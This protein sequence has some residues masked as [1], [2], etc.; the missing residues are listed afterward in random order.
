MNFRIRTVLLV[1]ATGAT[2]CGA[3]DSI[4]CGSEENPATLRIVDQ[5]P[6][7]GAKVA[8][9][10]I[11]EAFTLKDAFFYL[12]P[13]EFDSY[14]PSEWSE[15]DSGKDIKYSRRVSSWSSAP[16]HVA[17]VPLAGWKTD[18]GCYYKLPSPLLSYDV[19]PL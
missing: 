18:S 8:S 13:L 9:G 17:L 19:T 11:D 16:R 1:L 5:I 14:T 15:I 3:D 6:A 10:Y 4:G 7:I 12:S 2:G